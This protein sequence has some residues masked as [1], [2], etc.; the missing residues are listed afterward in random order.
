MSRNTTR[1]GRE[2]QRYGVVALG[3]AALLAGTASGAGAATGVVIPLE[4]G[5]VDLSAVPVENFGP[6]DPM[7]DPNTAPAF[8]FV[9]VR[10]GGTLTVNVPT[11]LD[12]SAVVV[13]IGFDDD[14]DGTPDDVEYTN[15]ASSAPGDPG[16]IAVTGRGTANI[17]ITLP[18]DDSTGT[19]EAALFL[20]PLGTSLSSAFTYSDP[21]YYDL[22]FDAAG[23]ATVTLAPQLLALSQEPCDITTPTR[24]AFPTPITAG[25][26]VTLDLTAGSSL[27]ELGIV[28]LTSTQVGLQ[29]LDANGDPVGAPVPLAAQPTG[30]G[31]TATFTVPAGTTAGSYGLVIAEQASSRII[32]LV[33]VEVTIEAA[34]APAAAPTTAVNAGLRSNTGIEIVE[35]GSTGNATVAIG[36]GLLLLAGAGGV[37]VARTRRRTAVEG[38]TCE[39]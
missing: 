31:S 16:Y 8:E 13:T 18:A 36:A 4:P 22:L 27:R 35:T 3:A 7:A 20:E 1:R 29:P 37:A 15:T 26:L 33:F 2:A 39:A 24:C 34:A 5:V 30:G 6:V 11:Q 25:S 32:A 21:V 17:Q 28:D 12:T 19:D 9:D 10:Y 23:P 14:G 38:G